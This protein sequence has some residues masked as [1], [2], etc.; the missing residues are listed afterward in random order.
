MKRLAVIFK[1]AAGPWSET[2]SPTQWHIH[3]L[4]QCLTEKVISIAFPLCINTVPA[5]VS[6]SVNFDLHFHTRSLIRQKKH[7]RNSSWANTF[8]WSP[9]M[10]KTLILL[11]FVTQC[12]LFLIFFICLCVMFGIKFSNLLIFYS[13]SR[14]LRKPRSD[15]HPKVQQEPT[16]ASNLT[17]WFSFRRHNFLLPHPIFC[18]SFL[19]ILSVNS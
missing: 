15:G 11:C 7:S 6:L 12:M 18:Q 8:W 16:L 10:G 4:I 2:R 5:L 13:S 1:P 17:K 19:T 14:F 3:R 9:L